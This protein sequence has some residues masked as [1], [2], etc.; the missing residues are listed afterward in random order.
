MT[1]SNYIE[2]YV[3]NVL[4]VNLEI[5]KGHSIIATL[6]LNFFS[7]SLIT[8]SLELAPNDL[9]PFQKVNTPTKK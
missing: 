6:S 4:E 9:L 7:P 2:S 1:F 3:S 8:S 5:L